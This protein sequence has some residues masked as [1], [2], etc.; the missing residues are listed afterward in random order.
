VLGIC[1]ASPKYTL[2]KIKPALHAIQVREQ[3]RSFLS[4]SQRVL[5]IHF[6]QIR[7]LWRGARDIG[8][9]R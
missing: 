6:L 9:S 2:D 3:S 7:R 1:E 4:Q 5:L 8:H